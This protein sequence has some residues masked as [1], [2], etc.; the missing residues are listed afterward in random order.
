MTWLEVMEGKEKMR[1]TEYTSEFGVNVGCVMRGVKHVEAFAENT[2]LPGRG[3]RFFF[4]DSWFGSVKVACQVRKLGHHVRFAIKT[5][6]SR[7][8]KKS[9]KRQ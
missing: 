3:P 8:P 6:Y 7:T 9:W 4:G 2:H 1:K 5:I